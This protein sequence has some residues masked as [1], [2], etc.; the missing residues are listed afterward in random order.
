MTEEPPKAADSPAMRLSMFKDTPGSIKTLRRSYKDRLRLPDKYSLQGEL[1]GESDRSS[2]IL[3][4]SLLDDALVFRVAKSLHFDPSEDEFDRIFRLEGPL[5]T[6]SSRMEIACLFGFIEDATYEQLNI[7]REMRN[8]CAHSKHALTF[9][10]PALVNVT[11]RLF[12]PLG[13]IRMPDDDPDAIKGAF[14]VEGIFLFQALADGSRKTAALTVLTMLKN[15]AS[16]PPSPDTLPQ[17]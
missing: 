3:M 5:G 14:I 9:S 2:I 4:A 8:A 10:E 7:I 16:Q 11:K 17:P 12:Q 1:A 6:F 13:L 15:V